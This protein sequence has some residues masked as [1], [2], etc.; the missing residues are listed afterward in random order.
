LASRVPSTSQWKTSFAGHR[1]V[2]DRLTSAARSGQM[3]VQP[4]RPTTVP[5]RMAAVSTS[6][7]ITLGGGAITLVGFVV[8]L[9]QIRRV[10]REVHKQARQTDG[11]LLTVKL[12]GLEQIESDISAAV[13]SMQAPL[14]EAA[15]VAWRGLASEV[16]AL[17][18]ATEA[19]DDELTDA[20]AR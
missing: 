5:T 1:L 4:R 12:G 15:T 3:W 9:V 20:L 18:D 17:L 7:W 6:D 2:P 10:G 19:E 13:S 14:L 11:A 8:T 16:I